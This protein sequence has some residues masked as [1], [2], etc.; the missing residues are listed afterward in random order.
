MAGARDW[1]VGNAPEG[2]SF[3]FG[4]KPLLGMY[5]GEQ[6]NKLPDE[7]RQGQLRNAFP[8]GLPKDANGNIDTNAVGSTLVK[9][10]GAEYAQQMLPYLIQSQTS[11]NI[12]RALES[13]DQGLTGNS[14]SLSSAPSS[15][16]PATPTQ[17]G[18]APAP[19]ARAET[20]PTP[21][22]TARQQI[23]GGYQ[24]P[25]QERAQ[26]QQ[27]MQVPRPGV[28]PAGATSPAPAGAPL[29]QQTSS[30]PQALS[31]VGA[32]GIPY[33]Q[34]PDTIKR[35]DA[36]IAHIHNL[37]VQAGAAKNPELQKS[38]EA[39][40]AGLQT[41]RDRL[42]EELSKRGQEILGSQ[43]RSSEPTTEAKNLAS[44]AS[45]R[46]KQLTAEF[47][48]GKKVYE[49]INGAAQQYARDLKPYLDITRGLMS[50]PAMQSYT[51]AGAEF[52]LAANRL[53]NTV[54]LGDPKAVALQETLKKVSATSVLSQIN[55]QRDQMKEAGS[56]SGRLFKSTIDKIDNAI[57]QLSTSPG[58]NRALIE[59]QARLGEQSMKVDEL[60]RAYVTPRE[61]GGLGHSHLDAGFDNMLA[62]YLK[63][64]PA[65]SQAETDNPLL[66]ASPTA[67]SSTHND[68]QAFVQWASAMGLK[69][70]AIVAVGDGRYKKVPQITVP[71]R[72]NSGGTTPANAA[73]Q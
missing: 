45:E 4:Q 30:Q 11:A 39:K 35:Y 6:L 5:L 51:G 29:P 1:F 21:T 25:T 60:A 50:D 69:P 33:S 22:P 3:N 17:P 48:R 12:G 46:E 31:G 20:T 32:G 61:Q 26:S 56:E 38:L 42:F 71:L 73:P 47:D 68:Q 28:L 9:L 55:I 41:T 16:A 65:F 70:G 53:L 14:G 63:S 72:A 19:S 62:Q 44:G 36:A 37:G 13:V 66:L 2:A 49:G 34:Y 40:A 57:P 23:T 7:Y 67:P 18:N 54:G 15:Y 59:I 8:N 24:R 27:P 64:H 58:G 10:G 52:K 43:L